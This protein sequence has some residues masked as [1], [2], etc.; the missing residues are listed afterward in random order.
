MAVQLV[1][2]PKTPALLTGANQQPNIASNHDDAA[3]TRGDFAR[4]RR[5]AACKGVGRGDRGCS[6]PRR[7]ARPSPMA[8]LSAAPSSAASGSAR[9][10]R[11]VLLT[12]GAL[13]ERSSRSERS[14][15]RR[16]TPT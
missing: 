1:F 15:L 12:C 2:D 16:T 4:A 13:S 9:E 11:I 3:C 10:A 14:E 7:G 5:L 6:A 8:A